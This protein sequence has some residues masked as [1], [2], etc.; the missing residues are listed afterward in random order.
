[1]QERKRELAVS[2]EPVNK[3]LKTI[4]IN[5]NEDELFINVNML[6]NYCLE[7]IFMY[8]SIDD[9]LKLEKGNK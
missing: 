1:M 3:K 5:E 8:L 4:N 7:K 2:N 9:R 6:N